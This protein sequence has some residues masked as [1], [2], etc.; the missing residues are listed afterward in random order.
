MMKVLV[1][2]AWAW[3]SSKLGGDGGGDVGPTVVSG[4]RG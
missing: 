3:I 2:K 1:G 4:V